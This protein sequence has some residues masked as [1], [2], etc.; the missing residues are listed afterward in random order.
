MVTEANLFN[1]PRVWDFS[2]EILGKYI[3]LWNC[4]EKYNTTGCLAFVVASDSLS[5]AKGCY[6]I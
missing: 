5:L 1:L 3:P 2:V 6:E 4:L